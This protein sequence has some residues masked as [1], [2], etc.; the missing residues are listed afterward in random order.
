[1]IKN[2]TDKLSHNICHENYNDFLK[3]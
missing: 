3:E 1:V 2:L